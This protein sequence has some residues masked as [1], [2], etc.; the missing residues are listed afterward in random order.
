MTIIAAHK[1]PGSPFGLLG[2]LL[3]ALLVSCADSNTNDAAEDLFARGEYLCLEQSWGEARDVL[4]EFLLKN[5]NHPGAHFYLGRSYLNWEE[6]FRPAIA[7]GELQFALQLFHENNEISYIE[8]FP[9]TYFELICNIESVKVCKVEFAIV[10]NL[11]APKS[12]L[13]RLAGRAR[14]YLE[15]A[16]KIIPD[17]PEVAQY[18]EPVSKME[19][20]ASRR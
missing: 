8:R 9:P 4:R 1:I 16:R 15:A 19:A 17:A 3:S 20:I 12:Q 2:V 14:K 7:E 11:G 6:S 5:P 18:E 13:L 10:L